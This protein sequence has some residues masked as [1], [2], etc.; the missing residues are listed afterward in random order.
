MPSTEVIILFVGLTTFTASVPNDCGL[1]AILPR[2]HYTP[3]TITKG[4]L[5]ATVN[6]KNLRPD[7]TDE[8]T[9]TAPQLRQ[10]GAPAAVP[11][12]H[13][14]ATA[15][16][17]FRLTSPDSRRVEDH[18]AVLIFETSSYINSPNWPRTV[19]PK[20]VANEPEYSYVLL[21]GDRVTFVTSG[22]NNP[23]AT[24]A[25]LSLPH[26]TQ[27]CPATAK[28]RPDYVPP[29]SGVAAVFN[30]PEG[31]LESCRST[32]NE[33]P[34]GRRVD[35]KVTLETSGVFIISAS[36]M[37]MTKELRL[38]PDAAGRVRVAVANVPA[39]FLFGTYTPTPTG[40]VDGVPHVHAYYAMVG[41]GSAC[42]MTLTQ[43]FDAHPELVLGDC[44]AS[45]RFAGHLGKPV[46]VELVPPSLQS[47]AAF[48]FECSNTQWP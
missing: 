6:T 30:I 15:A 17:G 44:A 10:A 3:T 8:A 13:Q 48:N 1:K 12:P 46:P 5:A 2:V 43:W 34:Y 47:P 23:P 25:N 45:T 9:E 32:A 37:K 36:T 20:K 4:T 38:R 24:T 27:V 29:Y 35:T 7:T 14:H 33:P 40:Q 21:D 28:L 42:S 41:N 26:L 19:L 31:V 16:Q 18:V 11:S 39:K 22:G